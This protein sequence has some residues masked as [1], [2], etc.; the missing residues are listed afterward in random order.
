MAGNDSREN[1]ATLAYASS[2]D[3]QHL[4]SMTPEELGLVDVCGNPDML[5]HELRSTSGPG[6]SVWAAVV[7]VFP[8]CFNYVFA[9][10]ETVLVLEGEATVEVGGTQIVEL[11]PGTIASFTKGTKSRWRIHKRLREFAVLTDT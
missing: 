6:G 1:L 5:V 11:G 3:A 10:N 7:T 8:C 4:V 2:V 9:G